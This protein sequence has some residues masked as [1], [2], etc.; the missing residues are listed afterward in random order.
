MHGIIFIGDNGRCTCWEHT[1]NS[2][3]TTGRDL[4]GA[5]AMRLEAD[6]AEALGVKCEAC[7]REASK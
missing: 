5:Q 2:V 7:K 1:G 3:R 6:E 4:S